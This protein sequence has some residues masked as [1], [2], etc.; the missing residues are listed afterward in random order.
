ME[1]IAEAVQIKADEVTAS[2]TC[3]DEKT[4]VL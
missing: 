3:V 4:E 1:K 2:E